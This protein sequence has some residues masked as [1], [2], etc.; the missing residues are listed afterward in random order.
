MNRNRTIYAAL[1][2]L[3]IAAGLASRS[4]RFDLPEFLSTYAGDTLWALLIFLGLGFLSPPSRPLVIA[5]TALLIS[6]MV[7]TSQLYQEDW[8]NQIRATRPG[9]LVLGSGFLWSDF[10]CYTI[11]VLLGLAGEILISKTSIAPRR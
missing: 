11:G 9:A 4:P 3:V 8:L 1:I 10:A 6:F 5:G 2:A 7:E